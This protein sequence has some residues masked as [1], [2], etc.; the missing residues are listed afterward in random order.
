M[1]AK[2]GCAECRTKCRATAGR[3][4]RRCRAERPATARAAECRLATPHLAERCPKN[5]ATEV[6]GRNPELLGLA[7]RTLG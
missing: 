5:A 4:S 2:V 1:P 6:S 3:A 7:A